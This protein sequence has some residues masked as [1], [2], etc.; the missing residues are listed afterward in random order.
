MQKMQNRRGAGI[1]ASL[2][3]ILLWF[4][5]GVIAGSTGIKRR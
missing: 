3:G 2:V 4:V 1:A 5:G